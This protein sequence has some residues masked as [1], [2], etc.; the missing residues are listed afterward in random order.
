MLA[1]VLMAGRAFQLQVLEREAFRERAERQHQRVVP[2]SP[3]RG[4]IYDRHGE[5]MAVSIEVDS[6]Y[7]NPQKVDDPARTA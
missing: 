2:L 6:I 3:Q 1:F 7:V 5:E 4:T